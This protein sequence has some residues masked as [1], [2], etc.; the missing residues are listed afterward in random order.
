MPLLVEERF[1][2]DRN[3]GVNIHKVHVE[4]LHDCLVIWHQFRWDPN[5][6]IRAR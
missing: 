4:I 1:V 5:F 2:E 6:E 3:V